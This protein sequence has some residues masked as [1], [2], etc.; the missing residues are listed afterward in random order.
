MNQ[1]NIYNIRNPE[2]S[3]M[4]MKF[5]PPWFFLIL[6]LTFLIVLSGCTSQ[7]A[8]ALKDERT[9]AEVSS[10]ITFDEAYQ[11][12]S[13]GYGD[14]ADQMPRIY[15]IKG[16]QISADGSA[17]EWIFGVNKANSSFFV[18]CDKKGENVT[19]WEGN[20]LSEEISINEK[21]FS[22]E[23]LFRAHEQFIQNI[24]ENGRK[25]IDELELIDGEYYLTLMSNDNSK[26]WIYNGSSGAEITYL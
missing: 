23:D 10:K 7:E 25:T 22:P 20:F 13:E 26:V 3:Y 16:V 21:F 18:T 11:S 24:T 14:I 17:K 5:E 15:Y 19:P 4:I 2:K 1:P 6:F 12:I 8:P 9:P